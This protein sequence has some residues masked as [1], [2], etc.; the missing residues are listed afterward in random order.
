MKTE[1]KNGT[2]VLKGT[3]R[4]GKWNMSYGT[5]E[6]FKTHSYPI[7]DEVTEIVETK[8]ALEEIS[9]DDYPFKTVPWSHQEEGM[10]WF[11]SR[12]RAALTHAMGSGKTKTALDSIGC[13]HIEEGRYRATS[14]PKS[15]SC[16]CPLIEER[17]T[18]TQAL[19]SIEVLDNTVYVGTEENGIKALDSADL[20]SKT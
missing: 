20:S 5:V 6:H 16:R 7:P 4:D 3:N 12:K 10:K 8:L 13:L 15:K 18:F 1:L 17:K 9:L 14:R 11:L 2:L 19:T